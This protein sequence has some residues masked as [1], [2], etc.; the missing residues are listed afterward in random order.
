VRFPLYDTPH[1]GALR[2]L[3][4]NILRYRALE[5]VLALFYAQDLREFVVG[6]IEATDH[7]RGALKDE[8]ETPPPRVTDTTPRALQKALKIMVQDGVLTREDKAEIGKLIAYR[9]YI[10]HQVD[11]LVIDLS[12]GRRARDYAEF[13]KGKG[14]AYSYTAVERLKHYRILLHRRAG[15]KYVM[16]YGHSALSFAA[17]ERALSADLKRLRRRIDR[18]FIERRAQ[19]RNLSEELSLEGAGMDGELRPGHPL[20]QYDSGKLTLRG[21][22]VCYR[23]FDL[24]KSPL[25][26]AYLMRISLQAAKRRQ[27]M[28]LA[29]GG[30][31]RVQQ[32]VSAMPIRR[33]YRDYDD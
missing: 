5:M 21:I 33:F 23:L 17:I 30:S 12:P 11:D 8:G 31:G 22:E 9:N 27:G 4:H 16:R 10:A 32:D 7:M 14:I 3:E 25:A 15:R 1:G 20:H 6:C 26:V 29:A 2:S 28:W 19:E 18:L 24:G 13:I